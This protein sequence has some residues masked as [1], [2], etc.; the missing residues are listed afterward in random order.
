MG[1]TNAQLAEQLKN[2]K[3]KNIAILTFPFLATEQ[4]LGA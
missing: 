1:P 2:T 3:S 4:G